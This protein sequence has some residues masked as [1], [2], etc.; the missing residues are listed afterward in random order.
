MNDNFECIRVDLDF[1][2]QT[3][4]AFR[5]DTVVRATPKQ[6]FEVF[7]DT[8]AWV[9]WVT[10]LEKMEWTS[11]RPFGVGTTR[12]VVMQGGI[13]GYEKFI[14]WEQGRRMAFTFTACS[15]P[16]IEKLMEDYQVTDLGDGSCRVEWAMAFELRGFLRHVL[17]MV[18]PL[19]RVSQRRM[20]GQFKAYTE[21]YAAGQAGTQ[22][23]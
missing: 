8:Q 20:F 1:P 12:T 6:I 2:N 22:P 18:R 13:E 10:P 3:Q 19:L 9:E 5:A 7:E 16:I 14:A 15:K 17:W 11:P 23:A 4:N 21:N